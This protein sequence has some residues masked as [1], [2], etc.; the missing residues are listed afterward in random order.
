M[1][2]ISRS[3]AGGRAVLV[4]LAVAACVNVGAGVALALRDPARA[5]DLWTMYDW[6]RAWLVDGQ[7]LYTVPDAS[8]DYPPNAIVLLSPLALVPRAWLVPL[9]TARR[10]RADA[11]P[12]VAAS[13]GAARGERA[14]LA[15]P[16]LLFLCWAGHPH[17]AAVQR[18]CR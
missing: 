13:C 3:R 5:S 7:S 4:L 11:G 18:C 1:A 15:V 6:C 10:G 2:L 8:T 17:A 9:W 12:A 16:I 14:A